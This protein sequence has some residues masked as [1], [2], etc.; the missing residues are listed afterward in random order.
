M[1]I[2]FTGEA[3]L[4]IAVK[5]AVSSGKID[6]ICLLLRGKSNIDLTVRKTINFV[7]SSYF[8]SIKFG[9]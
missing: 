4:H 1:I 6:I 2:L 9:T 5:N 7:L 3:P 8:Q